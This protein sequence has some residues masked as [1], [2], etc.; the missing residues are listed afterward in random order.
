MKMFNAI[1]D[2]LRQRQT[3]L[4]R[5]LHLLIL[6]LVICQIIV[7]EF[8]DFTDAGDIS[9]NNVEFYGTWIHI[10]TGLSI[11]PLALLFLW[12]ELKQHGFKYYFPYLWGDVSSLKSDIQQL[13][14]LNLPEPSPGGIAAIVQGLGLGALLLV[15]ASG[16]SWFVSWNLHL[17]WTH[18]VKEIHEFLTGLIQ[19]YIIG[20]GAMGLLHIYLKSKSPTQL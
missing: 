9:S 10:I 6:A 2:Y 4:V 12:V 15:V 14:K 1:A 20:H 5:I 16:L 19:A 18:D 7:S 17:S 13:M 3:P 11:I 8:M